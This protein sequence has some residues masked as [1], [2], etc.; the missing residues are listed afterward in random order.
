M[1]VAAGSVTRLFRI[2]LASAPEFD[3]GGICVK[4]ARRQVCVPGEPCRELEPRVMQVLVAL[5]MARGAVVSR[6]E[7]I[8][9]CWDGRI[10]GDDSLN[11]CVVALRRLAKEITPQPFAIETVAR[12]G[13]CLMEQQLPLPSR[14]C[15]E[16]QASPDDVE[17]RGFGWFV[18]A[19]R[20]MRRP[21]AIALAGFAALLAVAAGLI[22]WPAS[23]GADDAPQVRLA[24]IRSLSPDLPPAMTESFREELVSAFEVDDAVMT[25]GPEGEAS[26]G[27]HLALSG[28]VQKEGDALRFTMH[29]RNQRSGAS[30]WSQMFELPAEFAFAPR[31]VAASVGLV[32]RCG[33]PGAGPYLREMSDRQLSLW[34]Q[35]CQELWSGAPTT[36]PRIIDAARRVTEAAPGFSRGWSS[37]AIYAM[38]IEALGPEPNAAASRA[39]AIRAAR[40]ALRLD[41]Q[42]SEAY[43]AQAHALIDSRQWAEIERLLQRAIAVR[44]TDCAC[45]H[46]NLGGTLTVVGRL[47]E[48]VAQ[49]RRYHDKVPLGFSSSGHLADALFRAGRNDEAERVLARVL[50]LWPTRD[51]LLTL[52]LRSG[53]LNGRYDDVA[54][55]LAN[56]NFTSSPPQRL[57]L[58]AALD[59]LRSRQPAAHRRSV[60]LL[61]ALSSDARRNTHTV[62]IALAALGEHRAAL[63]SAEKNGSWLR[64]V[65]FDPSFAAARRD[66]AFARLAERLGLIRYWRATGRHPDFC[67][68][69]D[70][71]PLCATL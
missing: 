25:M 60:E 2:E 8:E 56:P 17:Q 32:L 6:D 30:L 39:E 5:A 62:T 68:A 21:L 4:P 36:R 71:P 50:Q 64:G 61:T 37:L 48:A 67:R 14:E 16:P 46:A 13:Y 27:T 26:A 9:A 10:V 44:P 11:R 53:L 23:R 47:D 42:N 22:V 7:L 24:A 59:A 63:A 18:R 43:A 52:R 65:L 40:E 57:A 33:L 31:Q 58:A 35:F 70:A 15:A 12:V 19:A 3:L 1:I 51:D 45:E 55:V 69:A 29:L 20:H 34:L 54:A 41:P 66:P 49:Y 28:T 38:P